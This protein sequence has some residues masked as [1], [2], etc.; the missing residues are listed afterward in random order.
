[1]SEINDTK[2]WELCLITLNTIENPQHHYK[3]QINLK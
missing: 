3:V 1:M 2:P